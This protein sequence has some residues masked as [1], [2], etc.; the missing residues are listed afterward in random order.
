MTKRLRLCNDPSREGNSKVVNKVFG[1]GPFQVILS[2]VS[3][4]EIFYSVANINKFF[5]KSILV[6]TY[7]WKEFVRRN[8]DLEHVKKF[9]QK[10]WG[11]VR[12]IHNS[13]DII[14]WAKNDIFQHFCR[15]FWQTPDKSSYIE[16]I[17][18]TTN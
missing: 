4:A 5:Y 11:D 12:E 8:E 17:Y 2:F 10:K 9:V 13:V 15:T 14:K 16:M 18:K 3:D 7:Y 1:V 6:E